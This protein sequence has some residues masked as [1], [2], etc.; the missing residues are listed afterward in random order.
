MKKKEFDGFFKPYSK[1][2]DNAGKIP[3]WNLS[4]KIIQEIILQN[5]PSKLAG[6]N[7]K[8]MDAGGGTGRWIC[9]LSRLYDCNFVLYDLS[10]DMLEKAKENIRKA[11]IENRVA[12]VRGDLSNMREIET[13]SMDYIIS[14]YSPISFVRNKEKAFSEM[15]RVLKKKGKIIIMG[16]GY[17]NALASK[18]NNYTSNVGEIKKLEQKYLVKWDRYVPQLN[19]FSKESMEKNLGNAGFKI[20]KTYGVPVFVQP[21]AE[22][23]DPE[24]KKMS[25]VST[26]LKNVKYFK[27]IFDL[28]MKYNSVP[29]VANR[30]VNIFTVAQ[31]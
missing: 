28:E 4:D 1:N 5:I 18:I 31:K 23:F 17:F 25:R 16:H 14:I 9:E 26:S 13:E 11:K 20:I 24:N 29:F 10:E 6:K 15:H 2:V 7:K 27:K 21:G 30:G 19:V 22:D 8:V 3:F 12:I